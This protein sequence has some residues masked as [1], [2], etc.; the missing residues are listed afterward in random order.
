[1]QRAAPSGFHRQIPGTVQAPFTEDQFGS[2]LAKWRLTEPSTILRFRS[3]TP[4]TLME[5][6][7][8]F[9]PN[10]AARPNSEATLAAW[11][12]FSLGMQKIL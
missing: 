7:W 8:V 4:S 6:G 2:Y 10:F 9:M 1:M 3:R 5:N 12:T 11:M